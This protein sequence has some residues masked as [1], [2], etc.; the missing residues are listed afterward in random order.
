LKTRELARSR[1]VRHRSNRELGAYDPLVSD[2]ID[3]EP[4]W[5]DL[6]FARI[7]EIALKDRYIGSL[8]HEILV[9]LLKGK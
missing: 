2:A 9:G 7:L 6:T 8:D 5:P 1:W 4:E 3:V